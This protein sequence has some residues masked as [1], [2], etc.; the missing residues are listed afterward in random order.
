VNKSW[1]VNLIYL[2][3]DRDR[4]WA[5]NRIMNLRVPYNAENF[6]TSS[7]S[8]NSQEGHC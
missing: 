4:R 3:Q 8:V 6:L 2:A 1:D 5:V 7:V